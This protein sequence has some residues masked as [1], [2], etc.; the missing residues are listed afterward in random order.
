M[1]LLTYIAIHSIS[2][3]AVGIAFLI[4]WRLDRAD[5][6]NL[7]WSLGHLGLG[8][9]SV[10]NWLFATGGA[11]PVQIAALVGFSLALSCL[12]TGMRSF[13]GATVRPRQ[14]VGLAA[15]VLGSVVILSRILPADLVVIVYLSMMAISYVTMA[16]LLVRRGGS[17]NLLVGALLAARGVTNCFTGSSVEHG[18]DS[19]IS[20]VSNILGVIAG[21]ALLSEALVERNNR[22]R[23]RTDELIEANQRLTQLTVDLE[24][25]NHDYAGALDKAEAANKSKSIFLAQMSHELRTPLNAVIGFSEIIRDGLLGPNA[26]PVYREYAGDINDSGRHLLEVVNDVL[27]VSSAEGGHLVLHEAIC[28]LTEAVDRSVN[29]LRPAAEKGQIALVIDMPRMDPPHLFVDERRLRQIL[30]NLLSNAV[31]F[32][33][34]GGTITLRVASDADGG[35]AIAVEDTGIGMSAEQIPVAL[36]PFSQIDNHLNRKYEGT[37]LGLALTRRLVELHQ[38]TL[39]IASTVGKGTTVTVRLP[40]DRVRLSAPP[41]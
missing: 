26:L 3:L 19:S 11:R 23:R 38:G 13:V 18:V 5:R 10:A 7:L 30:I 31:K 41:P 34:A 4:I 20:I 2:N 16:A 15:V 29:T 17:M 25:R 22:L 32:T 28:T 33:P 14:V 21:I 24:R 36:Q 9:T 35:V 12:L 8:L 1:Q 39:E 40:A 37:G 27:D 6:W